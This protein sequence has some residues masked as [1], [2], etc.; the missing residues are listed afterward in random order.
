MQHTTLLRPG[1][2]TLEKGEEKGQ[3]R[4]TTEREGGHMRKRGKGQV[5]EGGK[6]RLHLLTS[7]CQSVIF[8]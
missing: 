4:E 2:V 8:S 6:C 5:V 3:E 7:P 1:W